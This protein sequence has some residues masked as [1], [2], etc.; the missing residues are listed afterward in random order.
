MAC[1]H[2]TP[3]CALRSFR[4]Q[5]SR[6]PST[7]LDHAHAQGSPA[8][9]SW[10]CLLKRVF[11]IDMEYCPNCGGRLQDHRR[12]RRSRADCQDPHPPALTR[13]RTAQ[14]TGAASS[15]CSKR[16]D[17][18][19]KLPSHRGLAPKPT[20]PLARH[21]RKQQNGVDMGRLPPMN[22]PIG[23]RWLGTGVACATA[24]FRECIWFILLGCQL[25]YWSWAW[26]P[27]GGFGP[28]ACGALADPTGKWRICPGAAHDLV[29]GRPRPRARSTAATT[30]RSAG[31]RASRRW[32]SR[33]RRTRPRP[34][35][36]SAAS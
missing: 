14:I 27:A 31:R 21:S 22:R 16:P 30:G 1:S 26:W 34:A 2:P 3:S 36:S 19:L 29:V 20:I 23:Q 7:Q 8:R 15:I 5:R 9:M 17:R 11:D 18:T 6:Q 32:S 28:D 33:T 25:L 35:T 13:P 12:D 10:A 24:N 4:V